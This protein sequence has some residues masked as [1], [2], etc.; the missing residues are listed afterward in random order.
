LAELQEHFS[1]L[2]DRLAPAVVAV[3]ASVSAVDSDDANRSEEL[4]G[5]RLRSILDRVTRTVGT[6]MIIDSDGYILTNEHVV[7][8]S[9]QLW[10]TTDD[11]KVYPAIVVGSDPRADLAVMKI[12]A[13]NLPTVHFARPE[14]VRRGQWTI[15]PGNPSGRD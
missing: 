6:G 1:A 10:V 12:P 4:N 11:H 13:T 9:E 15:A 2:A 7:E 5:Q 8:E 3:S 14:M